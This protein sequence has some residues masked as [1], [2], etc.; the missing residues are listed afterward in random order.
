MPVGTFQVYRATKFGKVLLEIRQR[1]TASSLFLVLFILV[2]PIP[3]VSPSHV[4]FSGFLYFPWFRYRQIRG[5][6][7]TLLK[8]HLTN[9]YNT[10]IYRKLIG[11]FYVFY[12]SKRTN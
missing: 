5:V 4:F 11:E 2:C 10:Y 6:K 3:F 8:A 9:I 1:A 7:P 12:I